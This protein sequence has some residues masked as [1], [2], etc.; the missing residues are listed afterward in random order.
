MPRIVKNW[1]VCYTV[2]DLTQISVKDSFF[3]IPNKWIFSSSPARIFAVE[4]FGDFLRAYYN[5]TKPPYTQKNFDI[6]MQDKRNNIKEL[7][8]YLNQKQIQQFTPQE[9]EIIR[10]SLGDLH[11]VNR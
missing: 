8:Y 3:F 5:N 11:R 9:I 2:D 6:F 4:T 1:N 7:L 10:D